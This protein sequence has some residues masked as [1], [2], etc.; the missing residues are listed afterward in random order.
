MIGNHPCEVTTIINL[1]PGKHGIRKK[2]NF[3]R[4]VITDK[5]YIAI[6]RL[7]D[8]I[9]TF[10][11]KYECFLLT[12]INRN[13]Y[14]EYMDHI[15]KFHSMKLS[16]INNVHEIKEIFDKGVAIEINL[17]IV[18]FK[19]KEFCRVSDYKTYN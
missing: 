6:L 18:K 8:T 11:Q 17:L 14:I 15:N 2:R 12:D 1:N 7:S 4:D 3:A 5:E 10:S 13:G 19:E 9:E 16:N